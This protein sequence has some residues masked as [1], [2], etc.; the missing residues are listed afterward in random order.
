[1]TD[2]W[3]G[4]WKS[5]NIPLYYVYVSTE[6][7]CPPTLWHKQPIGSSFPWIKQTLQW[8]WRGSVGFMD[9]PRPFA[10]LWHWTLTARPCRHGCGCSLSSFYKR[11]AAPGTALRYILYFSLAYLSSPPLVSYSLTCYDNAWGG[12]SGFKCVCLSRQS[13]RYFKALAVSQRRLWHLLSPVIML[14]IVL[15]GELDSRA[16]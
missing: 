5:V 7:R 1:M 14:L 4:S 16:D 13:L 9:G 10:D 11:S 6:R 8:A 15:F 12:G 2:E 3:K